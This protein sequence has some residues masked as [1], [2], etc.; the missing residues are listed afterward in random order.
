LPIVPALDCPW[1]NIR[2]L[3]VLTVTTMIAVTVV[4]E[5]M[6]QRAR[7]KEQKGE[8][9]EH[10]GCVFGQKIEACDSQEAEQHDAATCTP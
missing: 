5:E 6:H 7:Q 2:S 8:R 1:A 9:T 3:V 10:V 4:H